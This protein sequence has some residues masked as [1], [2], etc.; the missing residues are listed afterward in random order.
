MDPLLPNALNHYGE[1]LFSK[2]DLDGARRNLERAKELG[3]A[4]GDI[5]LWS[6]SLVQGRETEAR[7]ELERAIATFGA[8]LPSTAG[9]VIAAGIL[10]EGEARTRALALVR[11]LVAQ[12]AYADSGMLAQALIRLG[13]PDEALA[14]MGERPM[15]SSLGINV[16]W[17][18]GGERARTSPDFP[19]FARKV[20][21]AALWDQ[22]GPP[23]LCRKEANGDYRC[24]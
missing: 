15:N 9:P 4:N 18:F 19:E 21:Y 7:A 6:V 3:A 24:R 23:D 2:G 12:P 10:A 11:S 20:G 5:F 16:I 22:Y 13:A 17:R 1:V 8:N 14:M